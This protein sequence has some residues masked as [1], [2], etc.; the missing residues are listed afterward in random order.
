MWE[1]AFEMSYGKSTSHFTRFF[2][3]C[4]SVRVF[5]FHFTQIRTDICKN[6]KNV[7]VIL[8]DSEYVC[9]NKNDP[10]KKLLR[11]ILQTEIVILPSKKKLQYNSIS[12]YIYQNVLYLCTHLWETVFDAFFVW[13]LVGWVVVK[14]YCF[15]HSWW[16]I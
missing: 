14:V 16:V 10:I 6:P 12:T 2:L 13:G 7:L 5:A 11:S 9:G 1:N 15:I 4:T 3:L 8:L